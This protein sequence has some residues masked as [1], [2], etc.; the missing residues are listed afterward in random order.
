MTDTALIAAIKVEL[1]FL[2]ERGYATTSQRVADLCKRFE[3]LSEAH[4]LL[5]EREERLTN[6]TVA[7]RGALE[8]ISKIATERYEQSD[9]L[10]A[11]DARQFRRIADLA[12]GAL[13]GK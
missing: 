11:D 12:D 7:S 4:R 13:E 10:R 2:A 1:P 6:E 9:K 3:T 5:A 8:M